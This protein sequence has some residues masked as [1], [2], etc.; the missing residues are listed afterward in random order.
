MLQRLR[1]EC[2]DVLELVLLPGL[3]AVLPWRMAF[4][5]FKRVARCPW[6]YR[7][8]CLDAAR[9]ARALGL[10]EGDES[11]WLAERRL[12][13][14]L[15]RADQYVFRWRCSDRWLRRHV[16]VRG[17]WQPQGRPGLVVTFH[18]G[19]GLWLMRHAAACGLHPHLLAAGPQGPAFD[20]RWVLRRYVCA[21]LATVERAAGRAAITTGGAMQRVLGVLRA[22]EQVV[23][24]LDVPPDQVA[25]TCEAR[26]LGRTVRVP[27][28]LPALAV[29]R[30]LPLTVA[31]M[32]VDMATGRYVL[33]LE[34]LEAGS[35]EAALAQAL[36]DR[37]ERA[38]MARPASWHLWDQARRFFA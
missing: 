29:E 26:L 6:L 35:D 9:E 28:A 19:V 30:G 3:A 24:V 15:D 33:A 31:L 1:R 32:N 5:L 22:N 23:V 12:I 25:Q 34:V 7:D 27:C 20:G 11:A 36:Y 14:L 37:L 21:R 8:V 4:G 16:E 10:L 2:R 13:A 17:Q 38:M 18:W